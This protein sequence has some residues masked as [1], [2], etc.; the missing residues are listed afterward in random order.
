MHHILFF[1]ETSS[2]PGDSAPF[3][4]RFG[5]LYLLHF[6][7]LKWPLKE[8]RFQ[9]IDEIQENTMGQL[10]AIGKTIWGPKVP[11]LKGTEASLSYVQCFLYLISSS[12]KVSI[13]HITLLDTSWT[14]L[15]KKMAP[16]KFG[17]HWNLHYWLFP[18]KL[19]HS[20][21]LFPETRLHFFFP[22]CLRQILLYTSAPIFVYSSSF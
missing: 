14:D 11:T 15:I 6:P 4:P 13:F 18:R 3:W 9:T 16:T 12:V 2:D 8:N 5:A 10:M 19:Y 20:S 17:L 22:F 1:G 7:K 21:V